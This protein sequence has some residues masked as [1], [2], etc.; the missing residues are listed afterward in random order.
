VDYFDGSLDMSLGSLQLGQAFRL[1]M[2]TL[3]I[4]GVRLGLNLLFWLGGLLYVGLIGALALFAG[5]AA[6]WLGIVLGVAGAVGLFVLIRLAQRYVLYLV[7]A[8]QIAVMARLLTTEDLPA[9]VSQLRWGKERVAD[10]FGEVSAMFV[11]DELVLPAWSM[12]W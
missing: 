7:K 3:P 6:A 4:A 5:Q 2:R 12:A 9:G 11:V 1:V 8:A 10:R